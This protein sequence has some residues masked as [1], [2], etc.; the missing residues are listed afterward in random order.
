MGA[1]TL[2]LLRKDLS[3]KKIRWHRALSGATG[4]RTGRSPVPPTLADDWKHRYENSSETQL[5]ILTKMIG[6]LPQ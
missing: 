6:I 3:E 5:L 2:A 4:L 1:S